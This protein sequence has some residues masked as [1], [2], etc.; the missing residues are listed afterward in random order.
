VRAPSIDNMERQPENGVERGSGSGYSTIGTGDGCGEDTRVQS[1][2]WGVIWRDSRLICP[3]RPCLAGR[4]SPQSSNIFCQVALMGGFQ[5]SQSMPKADA[6]ARDHSHLEEQPRHWQT[7]R[8][9][10]ATLRIE[11]GR[12]VERLQ[13]S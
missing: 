8:A 12:A 13:L 10:D 11:L 7:R 6:Q 3:S 9:A 5:D 2:E 1:T 4:F